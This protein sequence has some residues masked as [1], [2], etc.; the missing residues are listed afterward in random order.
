MGNWTVQE[1]MDMVQELVG[2]PAGSYYNLSTRLKMLNIAQREMIRMVRGMRNT[3]TESITSAKAEYNYP[4]DFGTF[5]KEQPYITDSANSSYKLDVVD[6]DY[7]D[8]RY[9]GWRDSGEN[10]NT[11][12]PRHLVMI[13][14][15]TYRLY[16]EPSDSYTL[17][18]PYTP[19]PPELEDLDDEVFDGYEI[20]DEWAPGLAY[21]VAATYMLPRAPQLGREY[22]NMYET[23]IQEMRWAL[24]TNP[25]HHLT[26]RP[27]GYER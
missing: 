6:V 3:S 15:E 12:T 10:D 5:N 13:D 26:I 19:V 17:T 9:P 21:K 14:S 20:L 24:R 11:G 8:R 27:T 16:P 25:Q 22:Q 2:E 7:M 23:T 1:I 18:L 4:F